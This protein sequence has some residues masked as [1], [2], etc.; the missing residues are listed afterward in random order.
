MNNILSLGARAAC[1]LLFTAATACAANDGP[2]DPGSIDKRADEIAVTLPS[3]VTLR[4]D[5]RRC[6]APLCGGFFV[7]D[8]NGQGTEQYVSKL[9][10]QE[11]GLLTDAIADVQSAPA[12]E[13]VLRG[14][15]G[16]QEPL[17]QTRPFMVLEAFRGMPN[18]TPRDGD[19][20]YQVH[21]RRPPIACFVAPCPNEIASLLN[22]NSQETFDRISVDGAALPWVDKQWL[23]SRVATHNAVAAGTFADGESFPGGVERVLEASQVFVRL[24]ELVGPCPARPEFRCTEGTVVLQQRTEDRCMVQ[25]GCVSQN[26]CPQSRDIPECQSGYALTSWTVPPSGC[27]TYAC[28]PSFVVR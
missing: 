19:A 12:N 6:L 21:A 15:L 16:Q 13:L 11:S 17:Y 20:F 4:A 5:L 25:V 3:F 24:P 10:F 14:H 23:A 7:R 26:I 2:S 22:T 1:A 27:P 18:V 9:D 8:V 28:D